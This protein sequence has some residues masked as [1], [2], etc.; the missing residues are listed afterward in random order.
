MK[1]FNEKDAVDFISKKTSITINND[2]ILH[3]ID[4]IWDYYDETGLLE[5]DLDIEES[6]VDIEELTNYIINEL[7]KTPFEPIDKNIVKQIVIA[8]IEYEETLDDIW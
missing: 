5:I 1:E 8:E 6:Q 2:I 7:S 3:I 4:C